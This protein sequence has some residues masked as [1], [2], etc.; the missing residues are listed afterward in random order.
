MTTPTGTFI[1]SVLRYKK[2]SQHPPCCKSDVGFTGS[3]HDP[4]RQLL[5]GQGCFYL[6]SISM[7]RVAGRVIGKRT[8]V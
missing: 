5:Q 6:W 1:T 7:P 8:D 3:Y 4:R 2:I